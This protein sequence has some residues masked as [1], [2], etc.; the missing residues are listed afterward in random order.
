M[1]ITAVGVYDEGYTV[2]Y[3]MVSFQIQRREFH[4]TQKSEYGHGTKP[5]LDVESYLAQ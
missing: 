2:L 4:L 5:R 3:P 1:V